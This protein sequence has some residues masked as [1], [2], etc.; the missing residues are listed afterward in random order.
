M[1]QVNHGKSEMMP[2][3]K[4]GI[5]PIITDQQS[6]KLVDPGET[7]LTTEALLVD[8]GIEQPF[9]PAFNRLAITLVL[10]DV[11]DNAM[12][13]TD[14]ARLAGIEGAVGIEQRTGNDQTPWLHQLESGLKVGFQTKSVV[15][16][17][18]YDPGRGDDIA[19]GIGHRQDIAGLGA[20]ARLVSHTFAA[21]FSQCMA[22]IQVQVG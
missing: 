18:R 10:G 4:V 20:L 22:A 11:G 13:E 7:A 16:I 14:F 1:T 8:I 2:T 15:M 6:P 3:E 9:T 21:F 19:V 12:I 5:F 17:A